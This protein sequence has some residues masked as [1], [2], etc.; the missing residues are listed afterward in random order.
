M[1]LAV[2]PL[3]VSA[4]PPATINTK[5]LDLTASKDFKIMGDMTFQIRADAINV[6]NNKNYSSYSTN[7]GSGG[8]YDPTINT[9][10]TGGGV[11]SY[12][13]ERT[14]FISGRLTW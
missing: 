11:T 7:W 5:Q 8:N 1:L 6:F 9:I 2:L 3:I 12:S 10:S 4:T 14:L 13:Q